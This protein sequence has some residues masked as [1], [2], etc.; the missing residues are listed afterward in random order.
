ASGQAETVI[1]LAPREGD[2]W[3]VP[4]PVPGLGHQ[5]GRLDT[6]PRLTPDGLRLY[7]ASTRDGAFADGLRCIWVATRAEPTAD[8]ASANVF[9]VPELCG[10]TNSSDAWPAQDGCGVTLSF[11]A[12]QPGQDVWSYD[13]VGAGF[14]K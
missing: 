13:L 6:A 2:T 4:Q 14:A 10:V 3:G 8:W 11:E 12:R 1:A 7:F 9:P 5:S